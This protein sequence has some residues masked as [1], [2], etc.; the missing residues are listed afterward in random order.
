MSTL[1]DLAR[2]IEARD[3]YSSGHAAR[4]TA[5]A[6]IVAERLGWDEGHIDVLRMGAALHDIGKLAVSERVLRKPGPLSQSELDEV[7]SHPEE[8]ARMVGL[9]G[10]MRAAVPVVLHHHERWDGH[11]YPSGSAGEA[12]PPEARVLAVVDAFDAMTS[13]RPYRPALPPE[14]ALSELERCAGTQ[15]DPDVVGVFVQAWRQGAFEL[16]AAFRVAAS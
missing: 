1:I 6:E 2:A 11:G 4:V 7:R 15:F 3:P 10:T 16:P 14:R 9:I 13:D 5:L 12:I 8:G